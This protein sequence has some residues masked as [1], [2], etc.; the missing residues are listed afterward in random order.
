MIYYVAFWN[1]MVE[2]VIFETKLFNLLPLKIYRAS[3]VVFCFFLGGVLKYHNS[4]PNLLYSP[5]LSLDPNEPKE[6]TSDSWFQVQN[7]ETLKS[8]TTQS[9]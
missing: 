9:Q 7:I 5:F 8:N 4:R 1:F 3:N 2:F 6:L